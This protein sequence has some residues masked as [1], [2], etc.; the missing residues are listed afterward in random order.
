ME[1]QEIATALNALGDDALMAFI[2]VNLID[3]VEVMTMFGLST[4]AIRTGWKTFKKHEN[5]D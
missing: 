2:I 1:I 5:L 4:W 3:F